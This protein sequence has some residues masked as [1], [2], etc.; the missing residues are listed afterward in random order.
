MSNSLHSGFTL[1]SLMPKELLRG[2]PIIGCLVK[3]SPLNKGQMLCGCVFCYAHLV[4]QL[5]IS[6]NTECFI[7]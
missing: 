2:F 7:E 6:A 1:A 4:M 5:M 3:Q